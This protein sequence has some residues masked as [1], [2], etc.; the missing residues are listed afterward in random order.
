MQARRFDW[1]AFLR[2]LGNRARQIAVSK[3][4]LSGDAL[5]GHFQNP[6]TPQRCSA[7]PISE[8]PVQCERHPNGLTANKATFIR[9]SRLMNGKSITVN[10]HRGHGSNTD[11]MHNTQTVTKTKKRNTHHAPKQ[12]LYVQANMKNEALLGA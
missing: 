11:K 12:K 6:A 10:S 2:A 5:N 9:R 7:A 1:S 8:K 3:L 4:N